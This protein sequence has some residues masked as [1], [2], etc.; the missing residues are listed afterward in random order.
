MSLIIDQSA[1][2]V[3][4]GECLFDHYPD[5]TKVLAGAPLGVAWH[6]QGF[7]LRPL[8]ITR[9]GQDEEG[10]FALA[11]MH[12]WGLDT[13]AVQIDPKYSTGSVIV[14]NK[15]GD[16]HFEI[17]PDQAW[18]Y[19][20]SHL[21]LEWIRT[22][23]CSMIYAGTLAQ[24]SHISHKTFQRL[25]LEANLPIFIDIN[26]R[27]PWNETHIIEQCLEEAH[28]LKLNDEELVKLGGTVEQLKL[29]HDIDTIYLT[30]GDKGAIAIG[31]QGEVEINNTNTIEIV[32]TVGA[33]DAFTAVCILGLHKA[34]TQQQIV[35]RASEFAEKICQTQGATSLKKQQYADFLEKWN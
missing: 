32:D 2:P 7:G 18:D 34:W 21:P 12:Q 4:F 22:L 6:L 35:A 25:I 19:I 11:A 33:G 26:I 16:N 30:S 10:E 29:Q 28:W 27:E 14:S 8:L 15:T 24:R 3:I 23:P 20:T 5:G 17:K 9:I 1:R 31:E 13:C